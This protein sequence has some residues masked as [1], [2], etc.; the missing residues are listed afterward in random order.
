MTNTETPAP[1]FTELLEFALRSETRTLETRQDEIAKAVV[2][3]DFTHIARWKLS[4]AV[5]SQFNV[6]ALSMGIAHGEGAFVAALAEGLNETD[7]ASDAFDR[8]NSEARRE[9]ARF[10]LSSWRSNLSPESLVE[11]VDRLH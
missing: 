9:A 6:W 8:A 10:L 3:G 4:A 1:T 5:K 11:L 7:R 2:L